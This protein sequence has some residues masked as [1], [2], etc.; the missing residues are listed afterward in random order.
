MREGRGRECGAFV[1]DSERFRALLAHQGPLV[2][3]DHSHRAP[4]PTGDD[5]MWW[6]VPC[7]L[8]QAEERRLR[9]AEELRERGWHEQG[10]RGTHTISVKAGQVRKL[11][12][13]RSPKQAYAEYIEQPD[14]NVMVHVKFSID[15]NGNVWYTIFES[16][17]GYKGPFVG[18][19]YR[20]SEKQ[21]E[22]YLYAPNEKLQQ[23][24][25]KAARKLLGM[26][27]Q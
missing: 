25:E 19:N 4:A 14:T 24:L 21:D 26:P 9:Q 16:G 7:L 20:W 5:C 23:V 17:N 11:L 6:D 2:H 15:K 22:E 12:E 1:M 10:K 13:Q 8:S 3:V 27:P 18:D